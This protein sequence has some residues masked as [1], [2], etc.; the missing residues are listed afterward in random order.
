LTSPIGFNIIFPGMLQ[1][2]TEVGLD[3]PLGETAIAE[4]FFLQ[5]LELQRS[6]ALLI[7]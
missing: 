1:L 3:L 6:D 2:A 4:I 7:M 5:K